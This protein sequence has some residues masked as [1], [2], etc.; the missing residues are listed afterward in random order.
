MAKATTWQKATM[1]PPQ[2]RSPVGSAWRNAR[3][4]AR[5][6]DKTT[7]DHPLARSE[8]WIRPD[9]MRAVSEA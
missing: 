3:T 1:Y 4:R 9:P 6:P 7:D 5:A 2:P 8:H